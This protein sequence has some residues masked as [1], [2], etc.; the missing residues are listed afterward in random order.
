MNYKQ[1]YKL[2]HKK[3]G[4]CVECSEIATIGIRCNIHGKKHRLQNVRLKLQRRKAN[5]C[6]DCG[7]PKLIE[8]KHY[9]LCQNCREHFH[10]LPRDLK[11]IIF[12]E[13][14]H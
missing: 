4:L 9:S 2:S 10:E 13:T 8:E 5:L 7:T 12:N 6:P 14:N 1:Q 11:E 3:L